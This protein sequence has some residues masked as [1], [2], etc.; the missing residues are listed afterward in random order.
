MADQI[1]L[2]RAYQFLQAIPSP[3]FTGRV[4]TQRLGEIALE[5]MALK[6]GCESVLAS[7]APQAKKRQAQNVLEYLGRVEKFV[8]QAYAVK[9]IRSSIPYYGFPAVSVVVSQ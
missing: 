4:S 1:D 9:K 3:V 5:L 8:T 7:D 2:Q 6:A